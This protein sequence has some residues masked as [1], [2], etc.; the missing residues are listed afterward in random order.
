[1]PAPIYDP[2]LVIAALADLMPRTV[3][4]V[5]ALGGI[6]RADPAQRLRQL[7]GIAVVPESARVAGEGG[8]GNARTVTERLA[9]ITQVREVAGRDAQALSQLAAIRAAAWERLEAL[10]ADTDWSPLRFDGGRLLSIDEGVYSWI[11]YWITSTGTT[12]V[13]RTV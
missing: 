1:M 8:M 12:T 2:G 3:T 5:V 13:P 4:S 7:P 9:V 11:D 6:E 10:R